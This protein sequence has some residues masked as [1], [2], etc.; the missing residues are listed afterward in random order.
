MAPPHEQG[1]GLSFPVIWGRT[2]TDSASGLAQSQCP[3]DDEL[4]SRLSLNDSSAIEV[5]FARYSRLILG[6]A[7]R[8]L[9]D[10]G[11]AEEIVQEALFSVFLH[12][13]LFE[14]SKGTPKSWIVR[15]ALHRALDRKSYLIRRGFYLGTDPEGLDYTLLGKTDLDQELGTKLI[16]EQIEKAF[17]ELPEAQRRTLE[18]F[19]FE[20]L[21]LREIGDRLKEPLGNVRHHFY[22]GLERLRKSTFIQSLREK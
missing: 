22:R 3:S 14:P 6:I 16:R 21:E 4:M 13:K 19:Y 17:E 9:H 10:R 2:E 7:L 11:E 20:G 15:I 1:Q 8:V 5:L 12:A 18:L